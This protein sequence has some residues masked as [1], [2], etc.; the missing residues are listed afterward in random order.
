MTS[1]A[2]LFLATFF[3]ACKDEVVGTVGLCPV[4]VSTSPANGATSVGLDKVIT[5]TFNEALNPAT[6]TPSS[7]SLVDASGIGARTS[8]VTAVIGLLT[9]DASTFT[10]SYTPKA[11]L[12]L[13]AGALIVPVVKD[14][15]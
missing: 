1:L 7:I 15:I 13:T 4:V 2:A 8:G 12:K 14:Q 6:I 9:Y 3:G 11:K 5:I 10:I